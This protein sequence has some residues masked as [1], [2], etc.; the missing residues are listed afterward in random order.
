M[1]GWIERVGLVAAK[2]V[3]P[4]LAILSSL[5]SGLETASVAREVIRQDEQDGMGMRGPAICLVASLTD[6]PGSRSTETMGFG[7]FFIL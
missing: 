7:A 6:R 5:A 3:V 2:I 4:I 1:H